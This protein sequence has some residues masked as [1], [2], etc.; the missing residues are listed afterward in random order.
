MEEWAQQFYAEATAP[1]PHKDWE[2][3][4]T[5]ISESGCVGGGTSV[6]MQLAL[7]LMQK[8]IFL[9]VVVFVSVI[10]GGVGKV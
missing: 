2:C 7:L 1:E 3:M 5:H 10:L 9:F 8:Y 6:A 4:P